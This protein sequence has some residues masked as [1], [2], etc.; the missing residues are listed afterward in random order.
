MPRCSGSSP[1]R[2][3]AAAGRGLPA[4]QD[5]AGYG[6]LLGQYLE[7]RSVSQD[8][9]AARPAMVITGALRP[10]AGVDDAG[11]VRRSFLDS[12]DAVLAILAEAGARHYHHPELIMHGQALV[13]PGPDG[14]VTG[15]E[16]LIRISLYRE[17]T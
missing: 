8:F 9:Q 3:G 14:E 5:T 10:A 15:L 2:P 4:V 1:R 12:L 7:V 13:D 11:A 17:T 16:C 6:Q